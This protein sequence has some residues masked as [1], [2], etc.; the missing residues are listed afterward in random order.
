[1]RR[2]ERERKVF[3]LRFE[4]GGSSTSHTLYCVLVCFECVPMKQ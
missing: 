4:G 1:M 2:G 3:V